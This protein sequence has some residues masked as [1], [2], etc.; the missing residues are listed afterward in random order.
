MSVFKEFL[1]GLPPYSLG[2]E[3]VCRVTAGF[4]AP[5]ILLWYT[6]IDNIIIHYQ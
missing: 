3:F 4:F 2:S 6:H 1:T 5:S